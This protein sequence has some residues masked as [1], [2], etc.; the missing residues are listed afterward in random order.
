MLLPEQE[1]QQVAYL[2]L[3]DR[4]LQT[5]RHQGAVEGL[6]VFDDAAGKRRADIDAELA[7]AVAGDADGGT[8]GPCLL[9]AEE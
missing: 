7:V 3:C 1:R 9:T 5:I 6:H 8:V 2:L 4:R